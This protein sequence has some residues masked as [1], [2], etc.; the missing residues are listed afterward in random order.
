MQGGRS[1]SVFSAS[2]GSFWSNVMGTSVTSWSR[3]LGACKPKPLSCLRSVHWSQY[4]SVLGILAL[5][6]KSNVTAIQFQR[7]MGRGSPLTLACWEYPPSAASLDY[8]KL[9]RFDQAGC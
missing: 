7:I 8:R 4:G 5:F 6:A 9:E 2:Q 1:C 3:R